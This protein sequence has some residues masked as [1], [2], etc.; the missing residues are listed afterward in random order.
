M[1]C[2]GYYLKLV[3]NLYKLHNFIIYFWWS[4]TKE[5]N[6]QKKLS[7]SAILELLSMILDMNEN[8]LQA[9]ANIFGILKEYTDNILKFSAI[10]FKDPEIWYK[11]IMNKRNPSV[12]WLNDNIYE[13]RNNIQSTAHYI[14]KKPYKRNPSKTSLNCAYKF[15]NYKR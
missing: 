7:F 9:G 1:N 10:S 4:A 11:I 12:T 14:L 3:Y 5:Q 15:H 2:T 6:S 8:I 13:A